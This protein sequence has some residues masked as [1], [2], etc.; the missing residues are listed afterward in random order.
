MAVVLWEGYRVTITDEGFS[1]GVLSIDKYLNLLFLLFSSL[2]YY[3]SLEAARTD[4]L[5]REGGVVVEEPAPVGE[6]GVVY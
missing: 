1:S 2:E 6:A 4:M 5:E 3:P